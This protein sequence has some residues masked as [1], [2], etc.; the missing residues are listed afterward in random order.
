MKVWV[1]WESGWDFA[2]VLNVYDSPEAA[3]KAW[4][5]LDPKTLSYGEPGYSICAQEMEVLSL[6]EQDGLGPLL[7]EF[8]EKF[9]PVPAE[10]LEKMEREWSNGDQGQD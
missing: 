8:D 9:G 10:R 2:E 5:N 3:C 6:S 4:P 7:A 1:V